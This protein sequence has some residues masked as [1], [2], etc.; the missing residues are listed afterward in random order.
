MKTIKF[1][2]LIATGFLASCNNGDSSKTDTRDSTINTTNTSA[3]N[4]TKKDSSLNNN[5]GTVNNNPGA[6]VQMEIQQ[7]PHQLM[8]KPFILFR[9]LPV[10][11]RWKL[12]LIN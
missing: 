8:K 4:S 12:N 1:A 6:M 5:S 10:G 7:I 9:L 2:C 3:M 11:D